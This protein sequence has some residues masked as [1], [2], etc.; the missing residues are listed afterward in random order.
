[1]FRR[2]LVTGSGGV[3]GAAI[4]AVSAVDPRSEFVF[5]TSRDC[6]LRDG[7]ATRGAFQEVRPDAVVH[8]AARSGGVSLTS[9]QPASVLRDNVLMTLNVLEAVRHTSVRKTVMT[10]SSGMYPSDAP[11]P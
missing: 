9:E 8:L 7:D 11:M 4:Q 10:L 2:I 1:M 5:F 6:D 3:L